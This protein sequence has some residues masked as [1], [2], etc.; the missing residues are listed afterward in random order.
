[1]SEGFVINPRYTVDYSTMNNVATVFNGVSANTYANS[2]GV[3]NNS[4]GFDYF[5]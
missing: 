2:F 4:K 1:M 3:T 5:K